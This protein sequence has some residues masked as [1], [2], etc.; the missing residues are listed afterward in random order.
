MAGAATASV[1]GDNGMNDPI[2]EAVR[3]DLLERSRRGIATY[4]T[5]L[6]RT[7]LTQEDWRRHLYEELLDACCYLRRLMYVPPRPQM[8]IEYGDQDLGWS[9]SPAA[10]MTHA[11]VAQETDHCTCGHEGGE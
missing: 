11:R 2:V 6:A 3:A 4:G 9:R 7:D 8:N 5:T 1:A 10:P